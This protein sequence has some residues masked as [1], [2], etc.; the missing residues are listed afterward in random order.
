MI[1]DDVHPYSSPLE[2]LEHRLLRASQLVAAHMANR[3]RRSR[4][5]DD[6][7]EATLFAELD[8]RAMNKPSEA[9]RALWQ[10]ADETLASIRAREA[11]THD[12]DMPLLRI[13]KTFGL[14]PVE[15]DIIALMALPRVDPRR[16]ELLKYETTFDLE[17]P[18]VGNLISLLAR[19]LDEAIAMRKVFSMEGQL[20]KSSILRIWNPEDRVLLDLVMIL[21]ERMV[22]ELLGQAHVAPELMS[23]L[24]LRKPRVTLDQ[25]VLPKE[26]KELVHSLVRNHERVLERRRAWGL[27]DVVSYGRGLTLLFAGPPG[28]GKTMLAHAVAHATNKRLFSVDA[29]RLVQEGPTISVAIEA[30]F[31][32]AQLLDAVLFFDECEQIFSDRRYGNTALATLLTRLEHFDGVAILATNM[33]YMLD[34][35]LSRRI[36]ARIDFRAPTREERIEIWRRHLPASMP[37]A[38]D[39]DVERLAET[40]EFT[41]GTIKN[42]VLT[43]VSHAIARNAERIE[44]G[45]LECGA[46]LQVRFDGDDGRRL[47]EPESSLDDLVLPSDLRERIERF[48]G[49]ARARSTALVEWGLS[50]TVGKHVG[51]CALFSGPSGT[52]KSM[53]AEAIATALGRPLLRCELPHIVSKYVGETSR[54]LEKLFAT[55]RMHRAVLVFDE[56]D[57]L[58]ARRVEVRH[59][60]D[61]FV[62]AETGALLTQLEH[63]D[64]VVILT[65]NHATDIDPA[66]ERRLHLRLDFPLPDAHARAAIWRRLLSA[67]APL[68]GDVDPQALGRQFEL[69]GG[70]IRNAVLTAALEAASAP[71]HQR[72]ITRA[73]LERAAREQLG[74][75]TIPEFGELPPIGV[76]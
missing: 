4:F 48:V 28:T 53:A 70:M 45:D 36:L 3:P 27:D 13:A 16:L 5:R 63:H 50:R 67:D 29:A 6:Q 41:G 9:T 31:R 32:E 33:E 57:A 46:R 19:D 52:G 56:A 18:T 25:V 38:D 64:G 30:I 65:T 1:R 61:R 26:T 12:V 69:S 7:D 20:I 74:Q 62:N 10:K 66:F 22:G 42:A 59:A 17:R 51:L 39:V 14:S 34:E 8:A 55:A 15:E 71:P 73:M 43:G 35:A 75:K 68:S 47:V 37:L 23:F 60:N 11:I 21:P 40:W 44:Q 54:S 58:F 24:S 49:A 2:H 72:R 76:A